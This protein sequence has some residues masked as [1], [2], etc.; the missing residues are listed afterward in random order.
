MR[1]C[2]IFL[3][4]RQAVSNFVSGQFSEVVAKLGEVFFDEDDGKVN[5][6]HFWLIF[7]LDDEVAEKWFVE[8]VLLMVFH[9]F[10]HLFEWQQIIQML[11]Q[12]RICFTNAKQSYQ[13]KRCLILLE[14]KVTVLLQLVLRELESFERMAV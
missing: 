6:S 11:L 3:F 10:N 8:E 1:V 7:E 5:R 13:L 14:K 4:L 12:M 9:A 2:L